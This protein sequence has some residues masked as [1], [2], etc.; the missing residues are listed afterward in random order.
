[1]TSQVPPERG[2]L[3]CPAVEYC[4][5]EIEGTIVAYGD[6]LGSPEAPK[7]AYYREA[8]SITREIRDSWKQGPINPGELF[9]TA[10]RCKKCT[11]HWNGSSC[12]LIARWVDALPA[13]PKL[14]ACPIRR[15]CRGWAE[16]EAAACRRCPNFAGETVHKPQDP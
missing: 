5:P 3:L 11:R 7:V 13:D 15:Q 16:Q 8:I 4:D 2:E 10:G 6:I 14:P 12:N 9:R 1:M